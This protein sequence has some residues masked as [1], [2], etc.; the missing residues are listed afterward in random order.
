MFTLFD[1]IRNFGIIGGLISIIVMGVAYGVIIFLIE[2]RITPSSN[3]STKDWILAGL[4]AIVLLP[5]PAISWGTGVF[6]SSSLS[7][8]I[9]AGVVS[10]IVHF[11]F[12]V[13]CFE[14]PCTSSKLFFLNF[15]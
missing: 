11:V 12:I 1:V 6:Y 4:A 10:F 3:T 8:F 2:G 13:F 7:G 15:E 5:F 14:L 9:V